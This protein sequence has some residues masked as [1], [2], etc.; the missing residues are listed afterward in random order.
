MKLIEHLNYLLKGFGYANT[1]DLCTTVFKLFYMKNLKVTLPL[2]VSLGTIREFIEGSLGL[3]IMVVGAFVWLCAAEFQT[4]IKVA[5]K[6]K[7]ERIQSRKLGRMFLKIG[8]YIQI[9]ALLYTFAS[10][11]ES[12]VIVGFEI[13]PFGW[14]YYIV[15]VGIVFQMVISYLENL[16]ALGYAEAKGLH[17]VVLRKFNKWFEFDGT[18]NGDNIQ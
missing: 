3:D 13:N 5:L 4:G 7:G 10:K 16:S 6:K 15:F 1:N 18:K 17:G 11:M 9:L 14:L 12:K 8:V 2:I